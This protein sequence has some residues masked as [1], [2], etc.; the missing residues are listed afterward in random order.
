VVGG[1]ACVAGGVRD[2]GFV[3]R[4]GRLVVV[5]GGLFVAGRLVWSGGD[6]MVCWCWCWCWCWWCWPLSA[7]G[8]V[9]PDQWGDPLVLLVQA[10]GAAFVGAA[11]QP[12]LLLC[13]TSG[14][15]PSPVPVLVASEFL[16]HRRVVTSSGAVAHCG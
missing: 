2:G 7:G 8:F 11:V 5:G 16:F 13:V 9:R 10:G 6:V 1:L 15:S 3:V 4:H 12:A 14:E